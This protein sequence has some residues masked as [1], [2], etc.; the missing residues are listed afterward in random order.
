MALG[1]KSFKGGWKKGKSS[2]LNKG[3]TN[4][5]RIATSRGTG[6]L[7]NQRLTAQS[8]K[9]AGVKKGFKKFMGST[10]KDK[11]KFLGGKVK[12]GA[13]GAAKF[14]K[15]SAAKSAK[16]VRRKGSLLARKAASAALTGGLALAGGAAAA[17]MAKGFNPMK[18]IILTFVGWIIT[19]LP[20]IIAGIKKFIEKI[21]P[22]FE[23]LGEWVKGIVKFFKWLSGGVKKLW[24]T[25]SGG[26]SKVDAEKQQLESATGKLK[27]TF[28]KSKKG[29]EDLVKQAKGEETG[30]KKDMD[31]LDKEVKSEVGGKDGGDAKTST[32]SEGKIVPS[33]TGAGADDSTNTATSAKAT[34]KFKFINKRVPIR[35]NVRGGGTKI[36]GYKDVKVKVDIKTGKELGVAS[37]IKPSPKNT[38]TSNLKKESSG[39]PKIVTVDVPIPASKTQTSK[40]SGGSSTTQGSSDG[41][42]SRDLALH[43]IER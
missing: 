18:F 33:T 42:N 38:T 22:I 4:I 30:L 29:Q 13:V 19:K 1:I 21:K 41:V 32:T 31:D 7:V 43:S 26:S 2:S 17:V 20:A 24:D 12:T 11:A 27:K 37:N 3:I 23:K 8:K 9:V 34:P 28:D 10:N 35:K 14:F 5:G 15:K 6:R 39:G 16:W 25:I 40:Q 36:V